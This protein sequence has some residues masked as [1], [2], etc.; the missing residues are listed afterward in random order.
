M[1]KSIDEFLDS[2]LVTWAKSILNP[3]AQTLNYARFTNGEYFY[4]ILKQSDPCFQYLCL[5]NEGSLAY[6]TTR[7]RLLNLDFTLRKIKHFYQAAL[8]HVLLTKL[9]DVYH[10]AKYPDSGNLFFNINAFIFNNS[11]IN[12]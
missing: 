7:S 1:L 4:E 10:I 3:P 6:E 5:P 9:P 2:A 8:N 11:V 12:Y